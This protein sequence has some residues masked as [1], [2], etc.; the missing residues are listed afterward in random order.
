[1]VVERD[2]VTRKILNEFTEDIISVFEDVEKDIHLYLETSKRVRVNSMAKS[3]CVDEALIQILLNLIC[4]ILIRYG[5]LASETLKISVDQILDAMRNE[6]R[7]AP[8][9]EDE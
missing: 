4:R 2:D 7:Q 1:M 5:P 8:L 6:I 3:R 9:D